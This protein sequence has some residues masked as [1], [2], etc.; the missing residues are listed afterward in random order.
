MLQI[1]RYQP[2]DNEAVKEL[3]YAGLAQLGAMTDPY[4]DSDLNDIEN[5]YINN[6]GDFIIGTEGGEIVAMGAIRQKSNG[7]GE[8]KRIRVR[9]DCQRRGYGRTILRK[10]MELA[11]EMGYMELILDTVAGNTPA[12]RL[13]EKSGFTETHHGKVGTYDLIFYNK[14]LSL[15]KRG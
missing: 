14:K 2:Q 12:Q 5:V 11:A 4:Y 1:R 7:C 10:L 6:H 9:Q 13:F 8:I 3:H 15:D